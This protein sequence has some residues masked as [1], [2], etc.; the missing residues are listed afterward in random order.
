[1]KQ[2]KY[3][4][5]FIVVKRFIL[6]SPPPFAESGLRYWKRCWRKTEL[7]VTSYTL[8]V[9]TPWNATQRLGELLLIAY[10]VGNLKPAT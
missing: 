5:F 9:R 7:Q 2:Y 8:Q 3:S 10:V 4:Y 6:K 1:M